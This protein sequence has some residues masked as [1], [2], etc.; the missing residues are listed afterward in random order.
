MCR[1]LAADIPVCNT[2][3]FELFDLSKDIAQE[4]N[5]AANNQDVVKQIMQVMVDQHTT[6]DYCGA[7][8]DEG[9][10]WVTY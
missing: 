8:L 2:T 10:M 4:N 9:E 1:S 7:A 3:T 6:G 5:I